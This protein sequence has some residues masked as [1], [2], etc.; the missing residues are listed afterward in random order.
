MASIAVATGEQGVWEQALVANT[1]DTVTFDRDCN[2]VRVV[3][4]TGTAPIYFSVDDSDVTLGSK[5]AHWLPAMAGASVT[6]DV[7]TGGD[8]VVKLKSAGTPS[9]SVQGSLGQGQGQTSRM[10]LPGTGTAGGS[11]PGPASVTAVDRS[12]TIDVGGTA[13]TAAEA[14]PSRKYLRIHNP[15]VKADRT[16]NVAEPLDY[17]LLTTE[18]WFRLNPG[19]ETTWEGSAVPTNALSAIADTTGHAFLIEEG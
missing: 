14:N 5:A 17:R 11:G 7:P 19:D 8:T 3:N 12:D 10:A 1:Q 4:L 16:A 15:V 9:Y 18:P 2:E 6:V 13:Q